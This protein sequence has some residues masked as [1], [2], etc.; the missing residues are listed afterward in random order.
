MCCGRQAGQGGVFPPRG[1]GKL[2]VGGGVCQV[3]SSVTRET[4]EA[5]APHT[6]LPNSAG[7]DVL[8]EGLGHHKQGG[9]QERRK[10]GHVRREQSVK[11]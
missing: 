6:P 9:E 8:I 7:G 1:R 11:K 3:G 5:H 4:S 2:P 10:V